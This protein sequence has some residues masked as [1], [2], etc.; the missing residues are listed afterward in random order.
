MRGSDVFFCLAIYRVNSTQ[1]IR[2][3]SLESETT[4]LLSENIELREQVIKLQAVLDKRDRSKVALENVEAT[5]KQLEGKVA[6]MQELVKSLG[7][8]ISFSPQGTTPSDTYVADLRPDKI[9]IQTWLDVAKPTPKQRAYIV[10]PEQRTWKSGLS[11]SEVMGTEGSL[12][13]ISEDA[14]SRRSSLNV[15]EHRRTS[16]DS[17]SRRS[18]LN[19]DETR[20]NIK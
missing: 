12:P 2:I 18:S 20:R 8:V 10:S 4:R 1:S 7:Q 17:D 15:D 16:L 6:E 13:A 14:R 19:I 11:F 9:L 3:R 5:K